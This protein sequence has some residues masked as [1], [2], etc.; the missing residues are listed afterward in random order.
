MRTRR[1]RPRLR[2]RDSGAGEAHRDVRHTLVGLDSNRVLGPITLH[3][4][5]NLR[6]WM[7]LRRG[8]ASV[9]QP[10]YLVRNIDDT[11]VMGDDDDAAVLLLGEVAKK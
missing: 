3:T 7:G 8:E 1:A 6:Y 10:P 11:R 9:F 4:S 2:L 5:T